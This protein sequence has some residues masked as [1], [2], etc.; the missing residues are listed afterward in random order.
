MEACGV[1]G[2]YAWEKVEGATSF[3]RMTLTDQHVE[4]R[5]WRK[6]LRRKMWEAL[7]QIKPRA[8]AVPGWSPTD[9]LSALYWC[10]QTNTPAVVMSESTE[11]DEPRTPWKERIKRRLVGL[12]STAL[13]GGTPHKD[14]LVTLGMPP[15]R[16]FLGYDAVD[17]AYFADGAAKWRKQKVE[18][19]NS[20]SSI[21]HLPSSPFFLASARF[22]EKKNL[23]RLIKAF[24]RYRELARSAERGEKRA[25]NTSP[26]PSPQSGEG[27]RPWDLVLLGD[28]PLKSDLCHLISG[29]GLQASVHLPGFIQYNELPAYYGLASAFVHASSTEQWGLVVNEAMACG[30]PVLVSNRC[31]CAK[32]LV[33]EGVNGFTFD[34]FNL[35]QLADLMLQ[36]SVF[37]PFRLS[38]FGDASR[39]LISHWGPE[40]FAAGL[41]QAVECALQVGP[42]KSTLAQR[43]ILKGMLMR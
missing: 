30:L 18:S 43:M 40:R 1:E 16:V 14:Y 38:A 17:N 4:D 3:T 26:R 37:Q 19:G 25:E 5:S 20:P 33:Q 32:D 36:L 29:L 6:E 21:F 31:G 27:D 41:Q 9:A 7:H 39:D 12:C 35:E 23:P 34:P 22:V 11:W 8:V 28:G 15:E 13:V 10:L 24:A 2:T 42:L